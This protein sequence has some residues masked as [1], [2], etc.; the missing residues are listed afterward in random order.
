MVKDIDKY[1]EAPS[2]GYFLYISYFI[3]F[4]GFIRGRT[5]ML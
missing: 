5:A 2:L 3:Y 1:V 4:T